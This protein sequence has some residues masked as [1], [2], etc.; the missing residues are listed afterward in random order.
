MLPEVLA[1]IFE[2]FFTTK[3][4]GEGTGMGLAIVH[5]V[6]TSHGGAISAAS[7]P[8]QGTTFTIYLSRLASATLSAGPSSPLTLAPP[9]RGNER[10]LVVEDD[11]ALARLAEK[12]LSGLGYIVRVCTSSG[13]ALTHFQADLQAFD[14]VLTDQTMPY[15]TGDVLAQEMRRLRPDLPIILI[16]GYSPL[17]D[18]ARV[19]A[20]DIDAFLLKPLSL[21]ELAQTIRQVLTKRREQQG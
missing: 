20:L 15:M 19:Q 1:R 12:Q 5:G 18:A 4:V 9:P 6:I 17:I 8:G 21:H 13:E 14:L 11:V 7:V 16:S 3:P 2:P 10:L